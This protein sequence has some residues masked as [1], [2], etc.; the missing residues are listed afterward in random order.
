MSLDQLLK[1][2][3]LKQRIYFTLLALIVFRIG[4]YIP[5]PGINPEVFAT[6]IKSQSI[7]FAGMMDMFSGGGFSRM[8]IFALN[9][10]PYIS[11]SIVV[12]LVSMWYGPF[13]ALRK[14]GEMGKRKLNKYT[15][16]LTVCL[17]VL[18]SY[19]LSVF[20][21]KMGIASEMAPILVDPWLFKVTTVLTIT[22]SVL[23][24]MWLG[25]QITSRG[26]GNGTS[27]LIYGGIVSGFPAQLMKVFVIG[28]QEGSYYI[29]PLLLF[30]AAVAFAFV[31]FMERAQ[32]K[33]PIQYPKRN[34]TVI[35]GQDQLPTHLPL[36]IN[37]AGVMP[38]IFAQSIMSLPAMVIM[39][40]FAASTFATYFMFLLRP[41][42]PL[43]M[44]IFGTLIV[45]F[46]F[47]YTQ[48]SFDP[49]ETADNL[50][51]SQA[52][53]PGLRPGVQTEEYLRKVLYRLSAIGA[54]YLTGICVIPQYFLSKTSLPFYIGGTTILIIVSVT[55]ESM[56]QIQS[57]LFS[58]QYKGLIS[59]K[60]RK[61]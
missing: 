41:G 57:Y 4:S 32:L 22:G 21:E 53:I 17:A 60:K 15:R 38:P 36:K 6:I 45:L 26:I 13:Q 7:G 24:L 14:E 42:H 2:K 48:L 51:K 39:Q 44:V 28:R 55:I 27:V 3:D 9:L 58:H 18:Q 43:N 31:V 50:K 34:V 33:V 52:F 46:S 54:V 35:G 47:V 23:F 49:K 10:G 30:F 1:A 8:A 11:S 12:Q 5:L 56:S 29:V 37:M 19:G 61:S 25:E 16:I 20:I 40:A 59:R